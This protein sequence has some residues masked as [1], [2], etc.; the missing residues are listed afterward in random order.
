MLNK[1]T[2]LVLAGAAVFLV[3][4]FA[5]IQLLPKSYSV[6]LEGVKYRLG[7]ENEASLEPVAIHM[8]GT[9]KRSLT[10]KGMFK[11]TID[12]VG[13]ILPVPAD[14]RKL[15]INFNRDHSGQIIYGYYEDG[16][17][18]VYSYGVI[19]VNNDLS[20]ITIAVFDKDEAGGGGWTGAD[21]LMITAPA[22]D[23]TNALK[24]ANE[25]M[26]DV[27]EGNPVK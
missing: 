10:G 11:G 7:A 12:V 20:K 16:Q 15:K 27:L 4:M 24:V 17:P 9:M 21:G 18:W 3:I 6:T 2:L 19:Y 25:L 5:S 13:E 1:R 14:K 26:N 8:Y 23:R 22:D